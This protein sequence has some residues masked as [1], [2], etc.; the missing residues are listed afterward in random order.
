MNIS[1]SL[2]YG[3][4]YGESDAAIIFFNFNHQAIKIWDFKSKIQRGEPKKNCHKIWD[5]CI[6]NNRT[7]QTN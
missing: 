4:L 2:V 5:Y 6:Q 1:G 7:E 3:K